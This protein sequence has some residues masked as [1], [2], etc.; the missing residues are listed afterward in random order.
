MKHTTTSNASLN[1]LAPATRFAAARSEWLSAGMDAAPPLDDVES[2]C[3]AFH[4]GK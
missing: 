1:V 4:T 2:G 3:Y